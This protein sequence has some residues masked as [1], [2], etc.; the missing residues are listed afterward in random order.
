MSSRSPRG[1]T[2]LSTPAF[3]SDV[4]MHSHARIGLPI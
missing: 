3:V 2:G 1:V 4:L